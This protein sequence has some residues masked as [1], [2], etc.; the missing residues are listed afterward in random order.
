M[1]IDAHVHCWNYNAIRDSWITD[2]MKILRQ[3]HLPDH[4]YALFAENKIDGCIAVQADQSETETLFLTDLSKTNSIINGIVGWVDLQDDNINE[5]LAYF[6]QYPVIKGWRHILQSEPDDFLTGKKF[7][8]GIQQLAAFNYTYDLLV[9]HHQLKQ[10]LDFVSAFPDQKFVVDHC[11]KPNIRGHKID[12]WKKYLKEISQYPNVYCKISGLL[13]ETTWNDWKEADFY[14]YLDTVFELF[15]TDR[16]LFGS[17]WPVLQLSGNYLQ[18]K[19]LIDKYMLQ[20]EIADRQKIF[21]L[22]AV[23]FYNL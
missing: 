9:V 5:R 13:T 18:W 4:L 23:K 3:D 22:N 17:D 12:D 6:S 21:G 16:L 8:N 19:D 1:T 2:D 11:G 7:R 15:G 14:P 10:A 20:Y